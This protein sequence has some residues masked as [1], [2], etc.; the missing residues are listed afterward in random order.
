[1]R[2]V[3]APKVTVT[4]Q[5]KTKAKRVEKRASKSQ[6]RAIAKVRKAAKSRS[7]RGLYDYTFFDGCW[8]W[9]SNTNWVFCEYSYWDL[10]LAQRDWYYVG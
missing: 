3:K 9:A 2:T 10:T 8:Y 7:G 6:K 4:H 1:M 5:A